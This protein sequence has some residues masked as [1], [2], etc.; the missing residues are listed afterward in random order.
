MLTYVCL[1]EGFQLNNWVIAAMPRH[2]V[3]MRV[4]AEVR[5]FIISHFFELAKR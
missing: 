1:Q 3:M 4:I 5:D 2:P